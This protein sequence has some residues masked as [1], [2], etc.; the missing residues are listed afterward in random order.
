[1]HATPKLNMPAVLGWSD[2][3]IDDGLD[4]DISDA[5]TVIDELDAQARPTGAI[6]DD[7]LVLIEP[8]C[9]PFN[10]LPK[11]IRPNPRGPHGQILPLLPDN[12][13]PIAPLLFP[14]EK[15]KEEVTWKK[16]VLEAHVRNN[17][18]NARSN[19]TGEA[20]LAAEQ[21]K[22]LAA[23]A[24]AMA[25]ALEAD[26][27]K[28]MEQNKFADSLRKGSGTHGPAGKRSRSDSVVKVSCGSTS[29]SFVLEDGQLVDV[30][31]A[32]LL[33]EVALGGSGLG[34]AG[35][36]LGGRDTNTLFAVL[37]LDSS[38]SYE[39]MRRR[40]LILSKLLHPDQ[41]ARKCEEGSE[42]VLR[43]RATEAFKLVANA[44]SI[45]ADRNGS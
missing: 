27:R 45:L 2:E 3:A 36:E 31:T 12:P 24:A 42:E 13:Y 16:T 35:G 33:T 23:E 14:P 44:Y 39:S 22:K 37:G 41:V 38:A 21:Q 30:E 40:Y 6:D 9:D 11:G 43:G 8:Y 34:G 17:V 28:R 26:R 18:A 1:L 10:I 19:P 20:E 25:A 7:V 4:T 29:A 5:S 32:V 15:L